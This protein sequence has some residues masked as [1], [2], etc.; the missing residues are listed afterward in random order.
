MGGVSIV[1]SSKKQNILKI[2]EMMESLKHRGSFFGVAL[3]NE[4]FTSKKIKELKLKELKAETIIGYNF[5]NEPRLNAPQPIKIDDYIYIFEGEIFLDEKIINAENFPKIESKKDLIDFLSVNDGAYVF[6]LLLNNELLIARDP[7]GLKPLYYWGNKDFH[8]LASEKKALWQIGVKK[9]KVFPPGVIAEFKNGKLFFKKFKKLV[10][11]KVEFNSS[12]K[13]AEK[14]SNLLLASIK[15]RSLD[16]KEA[17]VAF[18]GGIDSSL[19]AYILNKLGVKVEL[20]TVGIKERFD[21]TIVKKAAEELNLPLEIQLFTIDEL[22]KIVKKVLWII[23]EPNLMKLDVGIPVFWVSN[24]ASQKGFKKIFFGQ[25]ADELFGGY[26][27]FATIL[28]EEGSAACFKAL[29]QSVAKAYKENYE[30]DEKI[31]AYNK[32]A[33]R[34]PYTDWNLINYAVKLPIELKI[35]NEDLR[36]IVL[37]EAAKLLGLPK[38]LIEA[39]KKAIQYET[40]VHKSLIKI[41]KPNLK[42]RLNQLFNDLLKHYPL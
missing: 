1:I 31:A 32:I 42:N 11:P 23:E 36:K 37:R 30:R 41:L 13:A 38:N 25:G 10:Y 34:L 18:S 29:F 22:K 4:V 8:V 21:C 35:K 2:F 3:K 24:L 33:L 15:K 12:D 9:P 5:F 20:F 26:R 27:K 14:I 40:G 39:K 17:A 16:L 28:I 6:T 7:L 19:I